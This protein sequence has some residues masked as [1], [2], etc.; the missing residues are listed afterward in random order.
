MEPI[1]TNLKARFY[2]KEVPIFNNEPSIEKFEI[3]INDVFNK[4]VVSKKTLA[5]GNLLFRFVGNVRYHQILYTLQL[6]TGVYIEDPYFMGRVL[7]SCEPNSIV[8][9]KS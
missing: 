7:Y 4:G 9:M 8:N 2:P 5:K 3:V 1:H 6:E